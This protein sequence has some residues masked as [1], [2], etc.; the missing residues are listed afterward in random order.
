MDADE[1][2][3][4]ATVAKVLDRTRFEARARIA[5]IVALGLVV[6]VGAALVFDMYT[7]GYTAAQ[8]ALVGGD[9]VARDRAF[10][11]MLVEAF[12]AAI[13]FCWIAYRMMTGSARRA[14][15]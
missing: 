5:D 7:F 14:G 11:R 15:G 10:V 1:E 3:S 9:V 13:A 4:M 6:V 8:L 2:S 12:I